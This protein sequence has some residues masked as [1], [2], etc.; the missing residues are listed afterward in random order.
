M[1]ESKILLNLKFLITKWT[2]VLQGESK[3]QKYPQNFAKKFSKTDIRV[4]KFSRVFRA[5]TSRNKDAG[6]ILLP[7]S[8]PTLGQC[9]NFC[10]SPS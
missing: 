4:G 8:L 2:L 7:G 6:N 3:L 9:K 1:L 5:L 10:L